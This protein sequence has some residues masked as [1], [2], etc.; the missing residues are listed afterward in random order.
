MHLI[1]GNISQNIHYIA[2]FAVLQA[3]FVKAHIGYW[4]P[5]L[6]NW[7][8][9]SINLSPSK[10]FKHSDNLNS[11][12]TPKRI[13]CYI[14]KKKKN[15]KNKWATYRGDRHG[16]FAPILRSFGG[17][18]W[19]TQTTGRGRDRPVIIHGLQVFFVH[20]IK[21]VRKIVYHRRFFTKR[22][23]T[24]HKVRPSCWWWGGGRLVKWKDR[25]GT[26]KLR[27]H[28]RS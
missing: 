6:Y 26:Q 27:P 22:L 21:F 13:L 8:L 7:Y 3:Y 28:R 5:L 23:I 9:T 15:L 16:I 20:R 11:F 19:V 17:C 10:S 24:I 12:T 25:G 18:N 1:N 4:Y 14:L 2:R